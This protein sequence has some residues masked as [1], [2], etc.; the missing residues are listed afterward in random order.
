MLRAGGT[1][2]GGTLVAG[3]PP[4]LLSKYKKENRKRKRQS[5]KVSLSLDK[6]EEFRNPWSSV[7]IIQSNL[8]TRNVLI[9]NKLVLRNYFPWPI[10]NL[11][12]KD[13]E[14]LALRNNFRLT[15]KFLITKF[16]CIKLGR[17]C[18]TFCSEFKKKK[19]L[20]F[21]FYHWKKYTLN[22]F[23]CIKL[24]TFQIK[25]IRIVHCAYFGLPIISNWLNN[26]S[27]PHP[28]IFCPQ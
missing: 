21:D 25:F 24:V 14:H 26:S 4:K 7:L 1:G 2:G 9:R 20:T 3:V 17:N 23:G 28:N 13:K 22:Q 8:V 11:L 16:D 10:V 12:H 18:L 27:H 6:S 19:C 5:K 15:K